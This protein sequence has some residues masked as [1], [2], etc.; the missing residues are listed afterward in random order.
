MQHIQMCSAGRYGYPAQAHFPLRPFQACPR[1]SL[2]TAAAK[3]SSPGTEGNDGTAPDR[4]ISDSTQPA[5]QQRQQQPKPP[6]NGLQPE[7]IRGKSGSRAR[8]QD[9][10]PQ[11]GPPTRPPPNTSSRNTNPDSS[12]SSSQ[13][14]SSKGP[15][16]KY[17]SRSTAGD[18]AGPLTS[19]GPGDVNKSSKSSAGGSSQS[20][21]DTP[22]TQEQS[23]AHEQQQQ[24]QH[25]PK[26]EQ[27]QRQAKRGQSRRTPQQQQQQS[28]G[29]KQEDPPQQQ[30][31]QQFSKRADG[32][33]GGTQGP[34]SAD[35]ATSTIGTKQTWGEAEGRREGQ[36]GAEGRGVEWT[37][38]VEREGATTTAAAAS[39]KTWSDWFRRP[40]VL[41][42]QNPEPFNEEE[43][44][45]K[46]INDPDPDPEMEEQIQK[47][48]E[49]GREEAWGKVGG[50]LGW[51]LASKFRAFQCLLGFDHVNHKPSIGRC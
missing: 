45:F 16:K 1:K 44:M 10:K 19:E 9:S 13:S 34:K 11:Q 25:P 36:E 5:K 42:A 22:V 32:R 51:A 12:P 33:E 38:E 21:W 2:R 41:A 20:P 37:E 30:Q 23:K 26:E 35:L 7:P 14:S 48:K 43:F 39:P 17:K 8:R 27:Q 46:G 28:Q 40:D 50:Q 3:N 4:K 15:R 49:R 29:K 47:L 24:Q 31:Q 18:V 6:S